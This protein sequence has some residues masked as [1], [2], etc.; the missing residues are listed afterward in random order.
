M[1]NAEEIASRAIILLCLSDRCALERTTIGGR[2]YTLKQRDEQRE[3]IYKWLQDKGYN[4]SITIEEKM[5]FEQK[6]G[7]GNKVEILSMQIQYEAIEPCLWSLGLVDKLSG[8]DRFV[9]EDFH[10]LLEVGVSHSLEKLLKKCSLRVFE[11]V[12]LQ[13][14]ISMLWHWRARELNNSI[15]NFKPAKEVIISIFGKQYFQVIDRMQIFENGQDDFN[16]NNK[17]FNDL[18]LDEKNRIKFIAQWRNHAFE[19]IV[20]DKAWDEVELNT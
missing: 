14:E 11:D 18:N 17:A 6:V 2:V 19:W 13:N 1:K 8:Y 4:S 3:A 15:F 16:V 7:K 9:S 12:V 20:G 10:P 5:L